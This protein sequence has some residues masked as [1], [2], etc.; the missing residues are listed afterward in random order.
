MDSSAEFRIWDLA[1]S[2]ER[3]SGR[4]LRAQCSVCR[5]TSPPEDSRSTTAVRAPGARRPTVSELLRENLKISAHNV[6]PQPPMRM[7]A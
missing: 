1:R 3:I 4:N 2:V 6:T 7:K 5:G